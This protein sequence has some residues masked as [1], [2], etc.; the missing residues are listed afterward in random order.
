MRA[1]HRTEVGT[2]RAVLR[3][4]FVVEFACGFR[5]KAE[6]ELILPAKLEAGLR[7]RV[8]AVLRPGMA[9]GE[10]GGMRCDFVS[11]DAIL[12]IL[13][14]RQAEMLLRRHIAEHRAAIPADHGGSNAAGDVIVAGGDIG[15][16]RPECVK[17]SL[18]APLE[19]LGH[20]FLDEV[21]RHMTRAFVHDLDA[22]C[23]CAAGE[24][25]LHLKLAELRLV[26]RVGNRAGTQAIANAKAHIIRSHD[27][28][29]VVPVRVEEVFLVMG[30]TPFRHDAAATGNDTSHAR[31]SKRHE[32]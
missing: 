5:V 31:C 20:V 9:L 2:L 7:E 19:L 22:L 11:D 15:G 13:L 4:R 6:I 28:T 26:V 27:V 18:A 1:T 3:K 25:A 30:E 17:W 24:F 23:P 16:Q 14:V 12:H 10:I 21:H 32:A 8:V 29:D